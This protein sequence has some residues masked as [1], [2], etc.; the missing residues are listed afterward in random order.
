MNTI[1]PE[2]VVTAALAEKPELVV[3][4]AD[5]PAT[6]RALRLVLATA[7]DLFARGG[8]PVMLVRPNGTLTAKPMTYNNVIVSAHDLCRPV[9]LDKD[10][11]AQ[12]ITLP[13]AVATMFLDLGEWGFPSLAGIASSPLLCADGSFSAKAGHD[14]KSGIYCEEIPPLAVPARPSRDGAAAA[15]AT[16][17]AA[18]ATFPFAE[19]R[20]IKGDGVPKVD[21]DVPPGMAESSFIA[22]LLTAVCRPSLR[23]APGLLITAPDVS[24]AGSGKGLL[25]RAIGLIAF[26]RHVSAM[27]AG[28]D[29]QELD[30]R[31]TAALIEA[32]PMLLLD[33]LNA[34]SL[35]SD[36]LASIL[37]ERPAH[38]RPMG[39]ST[40]V[41]LNASAF[42]IVTG[43][44]LSVTEDLARRFLGC[45]LD[46][47]C[48]D[49]EARP[50]APGFLS[51]IET[52]RAEL[53]SA[54]LTIWRWGRQSPSLTPGQSLG[55]Y[56][57]WSAW[58]RDPL[59][60]LGCADPV[61]RIRTAKKNDPKRRMLAELYAAWWQH[62]EAR[63]MTAATLD[64]QVLS[65]LNP[66]ARPRQ[67]VAQR[68]LQMV[69]TRSA[70]YV[71]TRQDAGA[72]SPATY[73]L[74]RASEECQADSPLSPASPAPYAPPHGNGAAEPWRGTL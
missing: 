57:E 74:R 48:E 54:C 11:N 13:R 18:F 67:Y 64:E 1:A 72:W 4:H 35:R 17:R 36:T 14:P 49:P 19:A 21:P 39:S 31:L 41:P 37:T 63:P 62:H 24:G 33:N 3:R 56:E 61:E 8:I 25:G 40:M 15:L 45:D 44:G 22:A 16:L 69:G 30:K 43:N 59:L 55:S 34:T 70:G 29:R 12:A 42:I 65:I 66:Q 28:H 26:G 32:A 27:T 68:L 6:V 9:V 20:M 60:A 5:L 58:V 46:P 51:G 23:L 47:R 7:D 2:A 73:A 53:L 38:V 52:R 10:G 50:F 71:L